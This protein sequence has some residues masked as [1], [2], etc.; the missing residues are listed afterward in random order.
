MTFAGLIRRVLDR[1]YHRADA[2]RA[3]WARGGLSATD[4]VEMRPGPE[5]QA[6]EDD[7]DRR[8]EPVCGALSGH[9][10]LELLAGIG[11]LPDCLRAPD[12]V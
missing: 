12:P 11:A 9:E 2:H 4:I 6:I 5:R 10:R 7:T 1:V 8:D 3:A